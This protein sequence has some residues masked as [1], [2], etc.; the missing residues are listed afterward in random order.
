MFV[1]EFRIRP[2]KLFHGQFGPNIFFLI[3]VVNHLTLTRNPQIPLLQ[4]LNNILLVF[5]WRKFEHPSDLTT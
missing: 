3:Q 1:I 5:E 2:L 4:K